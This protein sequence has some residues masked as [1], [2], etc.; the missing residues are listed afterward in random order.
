MQEINQDF[1]SDH[2]QQCS[3]GGFEA[4]KKEKKRKNKMPRKR[5]ERLFET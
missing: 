1:K 5:K 3:Y 4:K 2:D